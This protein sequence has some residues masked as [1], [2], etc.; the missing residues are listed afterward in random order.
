M[1]VLSANLEFCAQLA[2]SFASKEYDAA[3]AFSERTP[4]A[5]KHQVKAAWFEDYRFPCGDDQ[6]SNRTHAH[7]AVAVTN[8]CMHFD[9]L[10]TVRTDGNDRIGLRR[11]ILDRDKRTGNGATIGAIDPPTVK[12]R[13]Q[14][15]LRL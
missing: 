9:M 13:L 15:R 12:L 6:L 10:S 4:H 14:R 2:V 5:V 7:C 8:G 1:L 11:W 3:I